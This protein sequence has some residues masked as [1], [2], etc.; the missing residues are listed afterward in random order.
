MCLGA[1]GLISCE[2]EE[3]NRPD[4]SLWEVAETE[5]TEGTT[6]NVGAD[7]FDL[8]IGETKQYEITEG[9]GDY[10]LSVLDSDIA[11]VSLQEKTLTV[12]GLQQGATEVVIS[13]KN[14]NYK[15]IKLNVYIT[16]NLIVES[17]DGVKISLPLGNPKVQ[18][19]QVIEGNGEYQAVPAD[20]EIVTATVLG[21]SISLTGLKAGETS[22]T[23]TDS[24]GLSVIIPVIIEES[25]SP[26][27]DEELE[28]FKQLTDKGYY[29]D[30]SGFILKT[31]KTNGFFTGDDGVKVYVSNGNNYNGTND[32]FRWQKGSEGLNGSEGLI[33]WFDTK[34]TT[35]HRTLG[36]KENMTMKYFKR[37]DTEGIN[38][39][40]DKVPLDFEVIKV[41]EEKRLIW[42]VWSAQYE[43]V[44][45]FG[46][47]IMP[48][49][50]E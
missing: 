24:R 12:K 20:K 50:A 1:M 49:Y 10:K 34:D 14:F 38:I 42:A 9:N 46:K 23:V 25:S 15:S 48:N 31:P 39:K 13:D 40:I 35:G 44:F 29:N 37:S 43:D 21:S 45:Y 2:E 16:D 6:L 8:K 26:Y 18:T 41:D 11:E 33:L 47:L 7:L 5:Q 4:S 19:I 32:H 27:T 17:Q 36:K 22:L 28:A 30:W 3:M